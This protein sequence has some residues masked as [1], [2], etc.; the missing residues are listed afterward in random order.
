MA[1]WSIWGS[2]AEIDNYIQEMIEINAEKAITF[3]KC[4][5]P[6]QWAMES[7]LPSKGDFERDQYDA[8]AKVVNPEIIYN[9]LLATYG[10]QLDIQGFLYGDGTLSNQRVALSSLHGYTDTSSKKRKRN[11]L[12]KPFRDVRGRI[13]A[14][15]VKGNLR[16]SAVRPWGSSGGRA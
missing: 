6:T 8:V 3:L 2:S 16:L 15:I 4:Y 12:K 14:S 10:T 13:G 11:S 9:A 5:V 1:V 7:G